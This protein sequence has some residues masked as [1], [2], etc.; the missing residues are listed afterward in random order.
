M[1]LLKLETHKI[2]PMSPEE[3]AKIAELEDKILE[4]IPQEDNQLPVTHTI[5]GGMYIRTLH[6][7]QNSV[8]IGAIIKKPTCLIISGDVLVRTGIETKRYSGYNVLEAQCPRKQAFIS[9]SDTWLSMCYATNST[10]L[11]DIEH[12]ITDEYAK[13][14]TVRFK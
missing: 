8:M 4:N 10:N 9:M 7:P 3:I 12:E 6:M 13:L 11:E 5:H 1:N 2:C 14:Q